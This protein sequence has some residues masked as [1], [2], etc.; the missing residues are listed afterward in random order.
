MIVVKMVTAVAVF[1]AVQVLHLAVVMGWSET[2][3]RGVNY[4]RRPRR[5]RVAFRRLVRLHAILLTPILALLAAFSRGRFSQRGFTYR[6]VAGPRGSCSPESFEGAE[7]YAPQPE[8]VFVVTQMRSGTTW[9][10]HLVYQVLTRGEGD[11]PAQEET[12]GAVSPWLE[13]YRTVSVA[14]A[15]RVGG[16]RPSRIIKTH[17]PRS[18]CPFNDQARYIYV[19]RHPLSCFASCVDYIRGNS[20]GFAPTLEELETWFC[21]E[22]QMWWGTWVEHVRGWRQ[23]ALAKENVLFVRYEDLADDLP[24]V[25]REVAEFLRI[26][27]LQD[28]ELHQIARKC[29]FAYMKQHADAFEMHPPH[30][31]QTGNA[32]FKSGARDRRS[33]IPPDV[34]ERIRRWSCEASAAAGFAVEELYPDLRAGQTRE[35]AAASP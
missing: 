33:D 1:L 25:V 8:D 6:G 32:F 26:Q 12:L 3:T 14:D 31:L 23:A 15:P 18:L 5:E 35:R 29:S 10:Q 9:M 19:V 22:E 21:S 28:P 24:A 13:S 34:R 16:E 11:L 27:P 2:R 20:Q 4:Y 17:L 7:K 30:L